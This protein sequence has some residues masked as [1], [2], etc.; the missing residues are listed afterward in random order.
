MTATDSHDT[1]ALKAALAA[2]EAR[3]A[4][5]E[6]QIAALTLM[7]E[8]LRRALYGR[9]SERSERLLGQLELALDELTASATEDE[10]AAEKAAAASTEVK[11]FVRR[12]PS[13]KP[14]PDHL[15]RERV[16]VPAPTA[17]E[18]CGS[19]RLSK[20]GEDVTETLEVIPR[21]WKVVQTVREKFTCRSC[22]KISQPPAPFHT[23]PRGWAGP[24]LLAMILFEKYGQH[25][26]LNRQRDRYAREGV[27]LSLSTLADQVGACAVAL[28][29]LHDLIAAHVLAASRL[30]GDDTTVPV[31]AKGK[32]DTARAWVYVRDDAPFA[33]PDPPAALFRYS[34]DRSGAHPVEHLRTFTGIL[35][36]DAYAGYRRLY[37]PDRSPGP[38]TEALCWA[39]GRRKF[40]ELAD[41]AAN[42]RRGK[43][44][45]PISPL[46]LEAADPVGSRSCGAG[47]LAD[48]GLGESLCAGRSGLAVPRRGPDAGSG[49]IGGRAAAPAA[50]RGRRREDRRAAAAGRDPDR[51]DRAGRAG[52]AGPGDEG[53]SAARRRRPAALPRLRAG[54]A[55]GDRPADRPVERLGRAGPSVRVGSVGE[56]RELL[57]VLSLNRAKVA[58]HREIAIAWWGPDEVGK[59]W[60][61]NG[62]MRAQ[63]RYRLKVARRM[64]R[65]RRNGG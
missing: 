2:S 56:E 25:Q 1:G 12:K 11:G 32:T 53:R 7:I 59:H 42:K 20:V 26:P 37:A 58:S 50:S 15:P 45:P 54:A 33:G 47:A 17:C 35:Q 27:D 14:F 6:A 29:P 8:K 18:C 63:V 52:G 48:P 13:R 61:P 55:D 19:D 21:R 24:N 41:I 23:V 36:A 22:E 3:A 43:R 10:L 62:W 9:R 46:A 39:H 57:I 49:G 44:A 4:A 34:R 40:Y 5:A 28:K 51:K 31:L 65:Q 60:D 38:V 30:H 64:A 16:V